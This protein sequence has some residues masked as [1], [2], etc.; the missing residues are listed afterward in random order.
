MRYHLEV[1]FLDAAR[2]AKRT[3]PLPD[4]KAIELTIPPGVRDGQTLRLRGK[5]QPGGGNGLAGDAYVEIGVRPHPLFTRIGNDIEIEL[6]VTFDEAVLGARLEVPTVSGPVTVA[7]PKGSSSGQRLRLKGKG[8]AP[9]KA[10]PGDQYV[11]LRIVL[12]HQITS[13][14]EELAQQWRRTAQHNPRSGL[15][16]TS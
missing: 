14:M 12:P 4:G 3:V 13:I 5:G 1:D 10:P 15:G 2:G 16:N 6:P 8:I 9:A 7:V 11:R